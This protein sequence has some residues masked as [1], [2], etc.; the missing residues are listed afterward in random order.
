MGFNDS[1]ISPLVPPLRTKG[2]LLFSGQRE[3][4]VEGRQQTNIQSEAASL[5]NKISQFG[6]R[7]RPWTSTL[8][9]LFFTLMTSRTAVRFPPPTFPQKTLH[10]QML[11]VL[12]PREDDPDPSSVHVSEILFGLGSVSVQHFRLRGPSWRSRM[13]FNNTSDTPTVT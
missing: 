13:V 2:D 5:H 7:L 3:V 6:D 10:F 8:G 11:T 1:M 4:G 12:W 9:Q